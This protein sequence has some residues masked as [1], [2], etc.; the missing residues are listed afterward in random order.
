VTKI[1]NLIGAQPAECS[2]K[3]QLMHSPD[4]SLPMRKW[5]GPQD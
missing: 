5:A 2:Y 1:C 3:R 4:P